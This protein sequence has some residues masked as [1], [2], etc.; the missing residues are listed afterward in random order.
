MA[1]SSI[2]TIQRVFLINKIPVFLLFFIFLQTSDAFCQKD[3]T[4]GEGFFNKKQYKQAIEHYL[5][6]TD[7]ITTP[8]QKRSVLIKIATSYY[9]DNN[10]VKAIQFFDTARDIDNRL[11]H[12]E[13]LNY[14]M[15]LIETAQYEK[16]KQY[17]KEMGSE[18]F[19]EDILIKTCDYALANTK[20]NPEVEYYKIHHSVDHDIYGMTLLKDKLFFTIPVHGPDKPKTKSYIYDYISK[21]RLEYKLRN[22]TLENTLFYTPSFDRDD[23]LYYSANLAERETYYESIREELKIGI[24]GAN[25]LGIFTV[26]VTNSKDRNKPK[27]LPFI[28]YDYNSTHPFITKDGKTLY[29]SSDLPGGYG[30]Y[31][32][33]FSEITDK[34]WSRPVN[35][36][37]K[38][39]TVMDEGYPFFF[40]GQLFFSSKGH[41]GYGGL[42]IFKY[43]P[44]KKKVENLGKPINSSMD[45]LYLLLL[46]NSSGFFI[47]N[48]N[49]KDG[50]DAIYFFDEKK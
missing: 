31:D 5:K 8:A 19:F 18:T 29:F 44:K 39:N 13:K 50:D 3:F 6:H 43:D 27:L 36:G 40:N 11:V 23:R 37:A 4:K 35:M 22:K 25:N 15:A 1:P 14:I 30:G 7:N 21:R 20:T 34:G 17:L 28:N 9:L 24:G 2:H 26:T 49:N 42:D 16:A 45:D 10:P 46:T 48:R 38:V 12:E 41:P 47:S 33:Y 32:I